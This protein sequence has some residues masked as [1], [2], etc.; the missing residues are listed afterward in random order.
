MLRTT[1]V[2]FNPNK[3]LVPYA[4]PS[5]RQPVAIRC[6]EDRPGEGMG[7]QTPAGIYGIGKARFMAAGGEV[8]NGRTPVHIAAARHAE[9]LRA[10]HN[11][12]P[13]MHESCAAYLGG[14]SILGAIA[15]RPEEVLGLAKAYMPSLEE[16]HFEPLPGVAAKMLAEGHVID[17][18]EA[19]PHLLEGVLWEHDDGEIYVPPVTRKALEADTHAAPGVMAIYT[20]HLWDTAGAW[21]DGHPRYGLN[22][23]LL[24]RVNHTLNHDG[25]PHYHDGLEVSEEAFMAAHAALVGATIMH[26]P[27]PDG[28]PL[29]IQLI[30]HNL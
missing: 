13:N 30:G 3:Y 24:P 12:Q 2:L 18:R 1:S 26:L 10:S 21:Y 29:E 17:P 28:I 8:S 16:R 6:T 9:R 25:D 11:Y 5:E 20:D 19:D 14:V 22:P 7:I 4:P 23:G 27:Q 15:T